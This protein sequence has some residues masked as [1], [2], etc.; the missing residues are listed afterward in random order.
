M[1]S[2][3]PVVIRFCS[4]PEQKSID[5]VVVRFCL[6]L[7]LGQLRWKNDCLSVCTA[8]SGMQQC[9]DPAVHRFSVMLANF[10]EA[11]KL[12]AD[13]QE[14]ALGHPTSFRSARAEEQVCSSTCTT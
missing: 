13:I 14:V 11:E 1:Q 2:I 3:D 12:L 5:I 7:V 9:V 6:V 8:R 10:Q 4:L